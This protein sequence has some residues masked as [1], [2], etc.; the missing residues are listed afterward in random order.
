[1]ADDFSSKIKED[2]VFRYK[3]N[4]TN[5]KSK[6]K[7]DAHTYGMVRTMSSKGCSKR[8]AAAILQVTPHVLLR[9]LKANPE[10]QQAWDEGRELGRYQLRQILWDQAKDSPQA[11]QFLAKQ[12]EWLGYNDG[13]QDTTITISV[14]SEERIKQIEELQQK[15]LPSRVIDAEVIPEE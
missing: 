6:L 2:P 9:W 7:D 8:E 10:A 3:R 14:S 15:V 13:K 1:M 5:Q 4:R 12:E 11:A